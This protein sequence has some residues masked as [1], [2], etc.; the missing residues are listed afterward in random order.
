MSGQLRV[1]RIARS[2]GAIVLLAVAGGVAFLGVLSWFGVL[3]W[4][5]E[6]LSHF[7]FYYALLGLALALVLLGVGFRGPAAVLGLV[8]LI[9]AVAYWPYFKPPPGMLLSIPKPPQ[10][11][12]LWAN[13]G[14]WSTDLD[15]LQR[16]VEWEKPDIA[17]FTELAADQEPAF[18]RLRTMLPYQS[19]VPYAGSPL[20]IALL[21]RSEPAYLQ[22]DNTNGERAPLL[23][24]R[25]CPTG[26]N[27]VTVLALHAARPWPRAEGA[28][29][30]QIAYAAQ[31]ARQRI[32]RGE[33]VVLVGDLNL[34][35][36]SPVFQR[37]LSDS[38]LADSALAIS[39]NPR[40]SVSTWWL[41]KSGIGLPID[42]AL[43]GPGVTLVERRLGSAIGSDHVPLI[44]E[45]RAWP[46]GKPLPDLE[47]YVIRPSF[48]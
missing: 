38:G 31:V 6:L 28:R 46:E 12:V 25:M 1:W 18:R 45:F 43:M 35:P 48:F 21:S 5:I 37:L 4:T 14:N 42:Q 32:E 8:G 20:T 15:A 23:V 19:A 36:F 44:F 39:E 34:T 29:D 24:A 30:R 16:L 26:P 27:C 10:V 2:L 3:H 22:F 7:R 13:L 40:A 9:N 17:V 33:R 47:P 11:K 41:G